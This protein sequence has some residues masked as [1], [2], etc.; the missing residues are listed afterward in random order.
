VNVQAN[1]EVV[2]NAFTAGLSRLSRHALLCPSVQRPRFQQREPERSEGLACCRP[3][4][5]RPQ[6]LRHASPRDGILLLVTRR[7]LVVFP[8]V[9]PCDAWSQVVSFRDRFDPLARRVPPHLTLVH[10]FM[11][12]FS[13]SALEGHV[14]AVAGMIKA[15]PIIL[16]RVSLHEG[17][18]LFLNVT[19][20]G[21]YLVNARNKLYQ[22][23]LAPHCDRD[24]TF[25]PHMTIGR[26]APHQVR[27]A[28]A[29]SSELTSHIDGYA[30]SISAY[31]INADGS[32]SVLFTTALQ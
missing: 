7:V 15:F 11:D 27:D 2:A 25:I 21:D 22:G 6:R 17:E 10:P 12:M 9:A 31:R 19:R 14:Q 26:V 1:D 29:A 3:E 24:S 4:V 5:G 23:A 18:Y 16:E 20:G 32:R 30:E 8:C 28:L 13:D